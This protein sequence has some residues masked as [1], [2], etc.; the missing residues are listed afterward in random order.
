MRKTP[1]TLSEAEIVSTRP[2]ACATAGAI[3]IALALAKLLLQVVTA[4]KYGY[5]RDELYFIECSKHLAWGYLDFPPFIA[6]AVWLSRVLLGDSLTALRF[7]PAVAGAVKV[8][9]A[10]LIARELGGGRFAQG[11]AALAVV[12]APGYLEA[13]H[14]AT[15]NALEPVFWGGCAY[16]LIRAIR[17]NRPRWWMLLGVLAGVGLEN[18][19]SMFFFGFGILVGLLLTSERRLLLNRRLW[20]A[21]LIAFLIFLPNLL[22]EIHRGFPTLQWLRYHRVAGSTV[23]LTPLQFVAEQILDLNPLAC[24]IWIAGLWY[25]LAAREGKPYRV[26]G[27]TYLVVLACFLILQ[28]RVYYLFP[29]YPMLFGSGGVVV[30]KVLNRLSW[31]WAKPAYSAA[32]VLSGAFLA[33][34][35]LP[36]LPVRTYIR[37]AAALDLDPPDIEERKLGKL[38]QLYADMFGW[39]EMTAAVARA[40][41]ELPPELR[42][43]TAVLANNYGEAGAIDFFGAKYG[44]PPAICPHQTFFE[45]RSGNYTGESIILLGHNLELERHCTTTRQVEMVRNDYAM[46]YENFPV[47]LCT[48]LK[49]PLKDVWPS[50]RTWK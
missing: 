17:D 44:L 34:F 3:V 25:Y 33:P 22:W 7:F 43:V 38:P 2:R 35:A 20:L 6:F 11:L 28:G 21:G 9:L 42:S 48:G 4:H 23:R 41:H 27:W 26:L 40:Y 49:R 19:Y 31:A 1:T 14:L 16:A 50:L 32:L 15:M 47:I 39:E 37:Y 30:E 24:P 5:F 13:D 10:G 29:A 36:V 12:V 46:P 18:K 45:W 8:L